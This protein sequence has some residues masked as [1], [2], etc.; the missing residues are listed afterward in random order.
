MQ[1]V[2]LLARSNDGDGLWVTFHQ[3]KEIEFI[4]TS[5]IFDPSI[6]KEQGPK[7]KENMKRYRRR[8][9]FTM[10]PNTMEFIF[11]KVKPW[12]SQHGWAKPHA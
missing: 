11:I 9:L 6:N 8:N 5:R 7:Q 2:A 3:E 4:I 12:V 1:R 10:I